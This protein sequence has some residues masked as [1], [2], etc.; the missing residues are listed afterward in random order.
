VRKLRPVGCKCCAF[1]VCLIVLACVTLMGP[2]LWSQRYRSMVVQAQ[3]QDARD[4]LK[5]L[6]LRSVPQSPVLG[7]LTKH[8]IVDRIPNGAGADL[9]LRPARCDGLRND[10]RSRRPPEDVEESFTWQRMQSGND[11]V[12]LFSAHF[13]SRWQPKPAVLIIALSSEHSGVGC[14]SRLC[15]LW[16]RGETSEEPHLTQAYCRHSLE[17][18][19][20]WSVKRI[21]GRCD[22]PECVFEAKL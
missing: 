9:Q 5:N 14:T 17:T 11:D 18:H 19:G 4:R 16:Y 8:R 7:S 1:V 21:V 20:R 15:Q 12:Y 6:V 13:D 22:L 2:S 10:S 3:Q